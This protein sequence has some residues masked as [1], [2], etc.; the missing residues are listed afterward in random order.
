MRRS[1]GTRD[2]LVASI[3]PLSYA[4]AGPAKKLSGL[5]A[6]HT[7]TPDWSPDGRR[8]TF[9]SQRKLRYSLVIKSLDD[10]SEREV[11]E[12]DLRG[13]ARP[14]WAPDGHSVYFK[15]IRNDRP[16]LHRVDVETGSIS[17]VID[18]QIGRYEIFPDNGDVLYQTAGGKFLRRNAATR[19]DALVHEVATGWSASRQVALSPDSRRLAYTASR[20]GSQNAIRVLRVVDLV[21]HSVHDL[22]F[23]STADIPTQPVGWTRDGAGILVEGSPRDQSSSG[24]C[25]VLVVNAA[26]G[27]A[28]QTG[29]H[30]NGLMDISFSPD[31]SHVAFDSGYPLQEA[32]VLENFLRAL[33]PQR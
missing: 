13:V 25:D 32:W 4:L 23:Q 12:V 15:A 16:G 31:A 5:G 29:I 14:K 27:E 1:I 21:N 10:G 7:G 2:V 19:R 17:T 26:T 6:D 8:V 28:R 30:V 9:F 11:S 3:D 24:C 18:E 33:D 20:T 22:P